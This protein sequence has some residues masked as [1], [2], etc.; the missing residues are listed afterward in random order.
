[1]AVRAYAGKTQQIVYKHQQVE[2]MNIYCF[3]LILIGSERENTK[4]YDLKT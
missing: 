3:L 4:C 1:M 2:T